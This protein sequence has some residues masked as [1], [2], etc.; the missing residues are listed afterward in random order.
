MLTRGLTNTWIAG[1]GDQNQ[2]GHRMKGLIRRGAIGIAVM[3]A[4]GASGWALAGGPIGGDDPGF[5]PSDKNVLKCED[6]VAKAAS[7]LAG[8]VIKCHTKAADSAVAMK[9]F[10][11]E[12]CENTAS[13]KYDATVA[14][15]ASLCP[16]CMNAT[17]IRDSAISQLDMLANALVYCEAGTPF[18]GDDGGNVPS[19]KVTLKCADG[20]Y[21]NISKQLGGVVKCHIK[22]VDSLF[23]GKAF[24]EETCEGT[25]TSKAVAANGKLTGCAACLASALPGLPATVESMIDSI[26]G[27]TYCASP[28]GAFLD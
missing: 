21:K 5:F 25:A 22:Q 17:A 2:G 19:G 16:P 14:K 3:A 8:A 24:D 7:K 13:G 28:S 20:A 27:T 4:V 11:E 12:A 6:G 26:N 15:L 9:T 18:G 10:D 23:K 1:N